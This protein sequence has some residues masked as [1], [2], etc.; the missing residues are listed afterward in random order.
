MRYYK[1]TLIFLL[2]LLFVAA[3]ILLFIRFIKLG[4]EP[5]YA[6]LFLAGINLNLLALLILFFYVGKNILRL[7]IERKRNLPGHRFQIQLVSIFVILTLIP[8]IFLFIIGSGLVTGYIERWLTPQSL[9]SLEESL[10]MARIYYEEKK[11]LLKSEGLSLKA[12]IEAGLGFKDINFKSESRWELLNI[13]D[14]ELTKEAY[15]RKEAMA[16]SKTPEG[17][18]IRIAL[19]T[20][21]GILRGSL[22]IPGEITRAVERLK[23]EYEETTLKL[24]WKFPLK[25][26]FVMT[27]GFFTLLIIMLALWTGLRIS[28]KITEPV[29]ELTGATMA[30]ASGDLDVRI[31]TEEGRNDEFAY[32][33]KNFN[34]MIEELKKSKLQLQEAL[35]ET[36][37]QRIRLSSILEN[38]H[39]GVLFIDSEG[40]IN[41]IN[42]AAQRI[43]G[44]HQDYFTGK[45]YRE[46]LNYIGS[47]EL[48]S[49]IRDIR[50][51]DLL[52]SSDGKRITVSRGFEKEIRL[53][54]KDRSMILRVFITAIRLPERKGDIIGLI[55]VFDDITEIINA[56]KAVAWQE[57]ASRIAHEVKNP[58]TPIKLSTER[59][60]KKWYNRDSDFEEVFETSTKTII[61]EVE[62]LRRL[63]SDFAQFGRMPKIE[64]KVIDL[65]EILR[66]VYYLYSGFKNVRLHL[67]LPP[68][69]VK[70]E[71]DPEQIKRVFI[72]IIDNAI[73]ALKSVPEGVQLGESGMDSSLK[74]NIF[75]KLIEDAENRLAIVSIADD[76]PGIPDEIKDKL[77]IPHF[78]TRKGGSGLGLAIANRIVTEH[79][80]LI[81][82]KDNSPRGAIFIVELPL[83]LSGKGYS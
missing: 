37:G 31:K 21:K 70:V 27:F 30:V 2:L 4:N 28:K 66:E 25:V 32:L 5:L 44:I 57:I 17:E 24:K 54:V 13:P 69:D 48:D 35:R 78:T 49:L 72:N 39:T 3:N 68:E 79:R 41:S 75:I 33:I 10:N 8:G 51:K 20:E 62:S 6:I 45:N 50:L 55:V 61:R 77:F 71:V 42:K 43:L 11:E 83:T 26:N 14:D 82:I 38:I 16:I 65:R 46:L 80:G 56:Q 73:E 40:V 34:F 15:S 23:N 12:R 67:F 58:L 64:K 60:I 81:K 74:G 19:R 36:E 22:T 29:R 1:I 7:Y 52:E 59:L 9:S 76:G 47:E 63:V 18:Y 53:T